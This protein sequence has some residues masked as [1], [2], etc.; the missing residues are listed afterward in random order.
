M[1]FKVSLMYDITD[2]AAYGAYCEKCESI[3][4]QYE[5]RFIATS[6]NNFDIIRIEGDIPEAV[7]ILVFPSTEHY[8]AF[9][10]SPEYQ[11]IINERKQVC[12][13]QLMLLER[14]K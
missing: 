2:Y 13:A 9:Y 1:I 7:N 8:M 6:Y 12:T 14:T 3:I 11:A 4:R 10:N 5:G